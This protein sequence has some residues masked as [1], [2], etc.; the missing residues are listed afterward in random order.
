MLT[1]KGVS[2]VTLKG[3][4]ALPQPRCLTDLSMLLVC[5]AVNNANA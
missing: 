2:V 4:G 5:L 1:S 3:G